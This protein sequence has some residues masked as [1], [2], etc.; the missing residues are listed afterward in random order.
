[1]ADVTISGLTNANTLDGTERVPMDQ[2]GATVDA[3]TADIAATVANS[4]V[5]GKVL[6]GYTSGAGTVAATDT[7]LQA[8]QKLN[9]NDHASVTIGASL[10]DVLSITGQALAGVDAGADRV[11]FWDDSESKSAYLQV[12]TGLAITGTSLAIDS[13]VATLTGT[14]TLTS[15]TLGNLKETVFTITD[16][17]GFVID[18]AN[19]PIQVVTLGAN[20]TPVATNFGAG[21]SMLLAVD[22][23]SAFAITWTSVGTFLGGAAAPAL[24][25][26][27]YSL[28]E[29]FVIAS[30]VNI[31]RLEGAAS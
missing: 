29:L 21:Q 14:Q 10:T 5:I 12:S 20:R 1:M 15:K 9:G 16:A 2:A 25:T 23:G 3:T 13:T 30:L 8:I 22:D 26:S 27:G 17:A 11:L 7:I 24:Y 4:V 31:V 18:P 28:F 6:T 19:G